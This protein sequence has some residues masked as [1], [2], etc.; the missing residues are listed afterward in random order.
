M[1]V[2]QGENMKE[3]IKKY[4]PEIISMIIPIIIICIGCLFTN[5]KPFGEYL[6]AKYDGLSQYASFTINFKNVLLGKNSLFYSFGGSLGYNFYATS[7]YYM[8]NPT[9][10][11]CLFAT[12]NT[13]T[14]YYTFL[15]FLRI[16][17]S[18]FTMCKY[19]KYKF[20]N[21]NN[22]FYIFF[23]ICYALMGY[24][25]CYF[26]NYM[27]FDNVMFFPILMIGLEKLINE[28]KNIL[29]IIMLTISILSNFYIGY[30]ECI[31]CLI[32]FIYNYI[33][34]EKKDKKIIKDFVISSLLSGFMCMITLI[35]EILE[36]MQGKLE[37]F[38]I[39]FQTNYFE[40]NHN[41][42]NFFY[43]LTPGS[44]VEYDIK[45]GT[46][47]IYVSL[48]VG[49]LVIKYYLLKNI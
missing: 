10:I 9:N 1:M 22:I 24:N 27:Y 2:L 8:F 41:Y 26:F 32:Y 16:S 36:L 11:L 49:I 39:D 30:M 23:S 37:H 31:F 33:N 43:K 20:K 28:R 4:I 46:L 21:Q 47:N 29:Y 44:M 45:Y 7:I 40:F 42:L 34:L 3:K 17:L 6:L 5:T 19:L 13:I 14:E 15:I 48:L 12:K 25:V 35:P 18:A 38:N